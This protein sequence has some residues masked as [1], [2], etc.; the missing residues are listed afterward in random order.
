M[1]S[2][3]M[4]LYSLDPEDP[5]KSC[6]SR[7]K[8]SCLLWE[9]L[10]DCPGHGGSVHPKATQNLKDIPLKKPFWHYNMDLAGVPGPSSG[11]GGAKTVM[12]FFY[13]CLKMQR[14]LPCFRVKTQNLCT[15]NTSRWTKHPWLLGPH[16]AWGRT[17]PLSRN[18]PFWTRKAQMKKITQKQLKQ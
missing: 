15:L 14:V 9:H 12:Y 3:K 6:K 7:F 8:S 10:W 2:T 4:V 13:T 1:W 11:A 18:E 16:Q 5:R 17:K